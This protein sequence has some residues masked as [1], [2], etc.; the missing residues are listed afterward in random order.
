[1]TASYSVAYW[2]ANQIALDEGSSF[3]ILDTAQNISNALD[4]LNGDTAISQIIISDNASV[5]V[6]VNQ[7]TTDATAL[8]DLVNANE[9]AATLEVSD[10]AHNIGQ[11]F[12]TIATEGQVTSIVVSDNATVILSATQV[13]NNAA[14]VSELVNANTTAATVE[15][16]DSSAN[17][18]ANIDAIEAAVVASGSPIQSIVVSNSARLT[19]SIDQLQNDTDALALVSNANSGTVTYNISDTASD[20]GTNLGVLESNSKVGVI[21]ISDNGS[22]SVS[23]AESWA[24][25][26]PP[27]RS[28]SI[29]MQTPTR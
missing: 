27:W 19:L 8:S 23:V 16:K 2:E 3:D 17:I 15:I 29:R 18:S 5:V 11:G 7:L 26:R 25:I 4:A 28:S 6:S 12:A 9:T 14:A 13:A 24:A 20:I 1:M 22:V 21:T 10:T